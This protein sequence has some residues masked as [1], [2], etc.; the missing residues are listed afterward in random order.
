MPSAPSTRTINQKQS[1]Q[2]ANNPEKIK[3]LSADN[4]KAAFKN[5]TLS[6]LSTTNRSRTYVSKGDDVTAKQRTLIESQLSDLKPTGPGLTITISDRTALNIKDG[7]MD[8]SEL[9][10]AMEKAK[11]GTQ[12]YTSGT[13]IVDQ[14]NIQAK[15]DD[16]INEIKNAN[17]IWSDQESG[18]ET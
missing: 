5:F 12:F 6:K 4:A 13:S 2:A 1:T 16:I 14:I 9:L 3:H 11:R 15:V 17:M 8:L 18:S 7:E 10:S